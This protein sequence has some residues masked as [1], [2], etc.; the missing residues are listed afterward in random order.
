MS[1]KPT[2]E[3][4]EQRV[5]ELEKIFTESKKTESTLLSNEER[6]RGIYEKSPIGIELYGPDGKL[7]DINKACLDIFGIVDIEEIKGFDLFEDPNV[8]DDFKDKLREGETVRCEVAFDFSKVKELHLYETTKSGIIFLDVVI[9]PQGFQRDKSVKGYLV[10]VQDNTERK[11]AEEA[12]RISHDELEQRVHERTAKLRKTTERLKK[13]VEEHKRT[14]EALQE[15]KRFLD[16]VFDSIQDGISVIDTELNIVRVNQAMRKRHADMLPLEGKK[17]YEAYQGRSEPCEICPTLR[18][19]NSRKL[20][21]NEISLTLADGVT[22]TLELF[23]F[24]MLDDFG[25]PRWVVEY[26]RDT[27][28]RKELETKL[29]QAHKMEAVGTLAGGIAHDFNNILGIILGNTELAIDDVPEWNRARHNL[30][31]VR[32]AC[33]RA[34]DVVKQ[35]LTFSRQ[36]DHQLRPIKISPIIE[37][38][39][40]L[41]R[42][43]IPTT[44]K[45]RHNISCES[46]VVHADATQINQVLINLC[47]N[48]AYAMKENGGILEVNL[49]N[50]EL[51]K[52]ALAFN[53]NLTPGKYLRLFVK[54]T[55][56]GIEPEIIDRIFDPYFT[57]KGV[58]EGSGMGLAV[59]H[60]IV[61]KHNG[62]IKVDSEIGKGSKFQVFLPVIEGEPEPEIKTF[63][64]LAKGSER[65]LF[66]D[67]EKDMVET[68]HPML[69]RL[70]YQVTAKTSSVE[71]L[72]IFRTEPDKFDL[73][74]TD[75]TMP[76]MTGRNLAKE[77]M[78][79]RSDIPIILCTGHSDQMDDRKAKEMGISAFVMKPIV[80]LEMANT[81]R[82]VLDEK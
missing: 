71:A 37:D 68:I 80:M 31:E 76:E 70:G 4:L 5:K 12:L 27:T 82:Q 3:Q 32:K 46:D 64:H 34:R 59:V 17:C 21:M 42:S 53:Q 13:E 30:Q 2:Y 69:E 8:T 47:A 28:E 33:L 15:S 1:S 66:I 23:A 74:I 65:I 67:D 51:D 79:I 20:E 6:F 62:T 78:S 55:G 41:L 75:M 11:L 36:S 43:S 61:M 50:I 81:I 9:A 57:T 45:I 25:S 19:L 38:A 52:D 26:V 49:E 10:L 16:T 40:K 44:I 7:M 48:A 60:G 63:E 18:S 29:Q 14:E 35:I 77:L 24:P 72:E 54:D 56:D 58:G 39:L 22:S 73:V